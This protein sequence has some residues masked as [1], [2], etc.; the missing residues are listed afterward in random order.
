MGGNRTHLNERCRT[1]GK[2][3]LDALEGT[4]PD[5]PIRRCLKRRFSPFSDSGT[6]LPGTREPQ[7]RAEPGNLVRPNG[8]AGA[9]S[10]GGSRRPA[11]ASSTA[12]RSDFA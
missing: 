4:R 9:R 11:T 5:V 2:P 10:R 3:L 8:T 12:N 1:G 7:R 6:L